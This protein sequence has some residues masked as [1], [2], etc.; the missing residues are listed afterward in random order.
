MPNAASLSVIFTGSVALG[1]LAV[2]ALGA[3]AQRKHEAG[4]AYQE[5]VWDA[6][7][8]VLLNAIRVS[9]SIVRVV[10]ARA[11]MRHLAESL[12]AAREYIDEFSAEIEAYGSEATRKALRDLEAKIQ[13]TLIQSNSAGMLR[14]VRAWK[15]SKVE[16]QDY[17][18]ARK[19]SADERSML[20]A[21]AHNLTE[22]P[23]V[24]RDAAQ[25]LI[26]SARKDLRDPDV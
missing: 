17:D 1:S 20:D 23:P 12:V 6:K 9:L 19:A 11:E 3:R 10:G 4:L 5:R 2:T 26:D 25:A 15:L 22:D 18:E 8:E 24:Y 14:S 7:S 21:I 16:E 13:L